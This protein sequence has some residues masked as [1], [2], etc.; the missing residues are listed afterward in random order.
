MLENEL[1]AG[2]QKLTFVK[3]GCKLLLMFLIDNLVHFQVLSI[4]RNFS[5]KTCNVINEAKC[6]ILRLF[7]LLK[8]RGI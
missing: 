4:D 6:F 2:S 1:A 7:A 8:N 3:T 5:F